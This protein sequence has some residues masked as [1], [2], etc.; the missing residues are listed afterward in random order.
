MT[1][2][3][4]RAA[5][6]EPAEQPKDEIGASEFIRKYPSYD[7]RGIIVG[8]FDTGVDP[9]APG[10][11]TTSDGKPKMIDLVDCTGSGDV[12]TSK[13]T[14]LEADGT[15]KGLSGRSL[16]VPAEW[17]DR[18]AGTKYRLGLKRAFELYPR[19]L[20]ARV[21]AERRRRH[22][23]TQR[24]VAE[25]ERRKAALGPPLTAEGEAGL[26]ASAD[27]FRSPARRPLPTA[28]G[29]AGRK[30]AE[31]AARVSALD[32]CDKAYEDGGP[33]YDVLT[34]KDESGVWR[35]CV[36]TSERGALGEAALLAPFRWPG[37]SRAVA[38]RDVPR[39]FSGPSSRVEGKYGTLDAADAASGAET[40][41]NFAVEVAVG[42]EETR[43]EGSALC[44]R[45]TMRRP[46]SFSALLPAPALH[47]LCTC[48]APALLLPACSLS[49]LHPVLGL[50]AGCGRRRE[51]HAVCRRRLARHARGGHHRSPLPG[52]A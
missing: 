2:T 35:V 30:G 41:C 33:V 31:L 6:H 42:G 47:L 19:P 50:A 15:L 14:E 21:K 18:A 32:A 29:E 51:D 34:Y 40:L 1:V 38:T 11:Q 9:G 45:S 37:T 25:E 49:C 44:G 28:E 24:A 26:D 23:E 27:Q 22:D 48:S 8:V 10:L 13:E 12:D 7:G 52:H 3:T 16:T 4:T 46:R 20:V 17:P 36:D 43:G 39:A 5:A